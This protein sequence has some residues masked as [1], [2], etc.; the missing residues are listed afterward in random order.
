MDINDSNIL[1]LIKNKLDQKDKIVLFD[2]GCNLGEYSDL[3]IDIFKESQKEI[4]A[5]EPIPDL[6]GNLVIKFKNSSDI[7]LN[8]FAIDKDTDEKDF[9]YLKNQNKDV[10][11]MSSLH[12]RKN[13]F[14]KYYYEKLSVKTEKL[15]NYAINNNIDNISL[16]KIDTEGNE[17]NVLFSAEDLLRNKKIDFIQFEY[18]GCYLDSKTRLYDVIL[19]LNNFNYNVYDV[20]NNEFVNINEDFFEDFQYKNYI[21]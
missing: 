10:V 16:L 7:I 19:Y 21:F 12:Y 15:D 13:V 9:F 4:H 17:L 18:G 6:F 11:G 5:F 1:K 8:N 2:V 3:F 14:D 20:I